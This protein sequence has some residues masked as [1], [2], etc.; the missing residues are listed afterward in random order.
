MN[1]FH[2]QLLAVIIFVTIA[3]KCYK[4]RGKITDKCSSDDF[5]HNNYKGEL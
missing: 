4:L 2:L 5:F 3:D 1:M